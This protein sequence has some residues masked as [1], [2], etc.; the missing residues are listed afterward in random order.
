MTKKAIYI[1]D[2]KYEPI[3][4]FVLNDATGDYEMHGEPS[5]AYAEAIV[6][7]DGSFLIFDVPADPEEDVTV[8]VIPQNDAWFKQ[9][10]EE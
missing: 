3:P 1:N 9:S 2:L 5:V 4:Y 7:A 6:E 8:S 10:E